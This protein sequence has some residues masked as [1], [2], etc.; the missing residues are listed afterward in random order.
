MKAEGGSGGAPK[1]GRR[2][3][4]GESEIQRQLPQNV[5]ASSFILHASSFLAFVFP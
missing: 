2:K 1:G 5:L 3:D 4:E